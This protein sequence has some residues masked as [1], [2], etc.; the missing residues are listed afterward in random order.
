MQ[1]QIISSVRQLQGELDMGVILVSHNLAV[2]AQMCERVAVMYAGRIVETGT[3][4]GVAVV[5]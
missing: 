1:A 3:P 4:G 5:T 2:V